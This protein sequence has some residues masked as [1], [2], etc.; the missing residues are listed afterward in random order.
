MLSHLKLS[1]YFC[2]TASG[3]KHSSICE[4]RAEQH[5]EGSL[6]GWLRMLRESERGWK[7]VGRWG[8]GAEE[9]QQRV[10]CEDHTVLL[11]E[12]EAVWVG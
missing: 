10:V 8:G 9:E 6:S 4:E 1:L 2:F 5:P 3:G 12:D 7:V 11:E